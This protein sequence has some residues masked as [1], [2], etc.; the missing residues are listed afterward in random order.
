MN[1]MKIPI[2][3]RPNYFHRQLLLEDDFLAEQKYHVDARRNHNLIVHDW[4]V[5]RGLA[6]TRAHERTVRIG[7]GAAIDESGRDIIVEDPNLIVELNAFRPHDRVCICLAYEEADGAGEN[8]RVDCYATVTVAKESEPHGR[9]ILATVALDDQGK[10]NEE[11]I[12]YAQTKYARLAAGSITPEQL[13]DDL[14]RGWL[15]L[16]FRPEPMVEGPEAGTEAGL[17]AFRVGATEALSPDPKEAGERDRGA[18][19]TMAIPIPPSVK[20]VTRFRIAGMENKGEISLLLMR[21][22][23]DP[24]T[25]KHV[26]DILIDEK[27]VRKEPYM[28]VYKVKEQDTA[29]DPEYHTLALW[30]KGTRRTAV[31]LVAVEF[32]Y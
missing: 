10:V 6:V 11:S 13:H 1:G 8:K 29:L 20:H 2:G 27:I 21:G 25:K 30:L 9:L 26:R 32:A 23:W 16:P 17:P 18:A 12:D 14:R 3:K 19:G 15:R 28:E 7:A 31:S 5:V 24:A 22:G 4:G